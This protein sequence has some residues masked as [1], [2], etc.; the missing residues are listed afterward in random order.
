M[1]SFRPLILIYGILFGL[2]LL[3]WPMKGSF[4]TNHDVWAN[5]AMFETLKADLLHCWEGL[6]Y[7]SFGYP[8][9]NPRI[10]YGLDY[11]SGIF[12]LIFN[13]LLDNPIWS[14]S[15]YLWVLLSL[16]AHSWFRLMRSFGLAVVPAFVSG[17][18]VMANP[19]VIGNLDNP[20]FLAF[21]PSWYSLAIY[22][23][24]RSF[25]SA[26][27]LN[28]SAWLMLLQLLLNPYGLVLM[29]P[30]CF[31]ELNGR[32]WL[33]LKSQHIF[34]WL[35]TFIPVCL[36]LA[37]FAGLYLSDE[38]GDLFN[39]A[40]ELAN[41]A[42]LLR[43]KDFCTG[44]DGALFPYPGFQARTYSILDTCKIGFP[45][46]GLM[47]LGFLGL[48]F[49]ARKAER[50]R[51]LF[52]LFAGIL[53]STALID[54][55]IRNTGSQTKDFFLFSFFRIPFRFYFLVIMALAWCAGLFLSRWPGKACLLILLPLQVGAL[56]FHY[57]DYRSSQELQHLN[58]IVSEVQNL[59]RGPT[60]YFPSAL[61]GEE[62]DKREYKYMY[63]NAL[64]RGIT[65]NGNFAFFDH[66]RLQTDTLFRQGP[67]SFIRAIQPE[68]V[69]LIDSFAKCSEE[70]DS[71]EMPANYQCRE[72]RFGLIIY[73]CPQQAF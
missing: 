62:E 7:L 39:P 6:P 38:H 16:N 72:T 19:F 3:P 67:V 65:F 69:V 9:A 27:K 31:L 68:N 60:A 33:M 13:Q 11:F 42:N 8:A 34:F 23:D 51:I 30:I 49:P 59:K 45:G 20:N 12:Y 70:L 50:F 56:P 48:L 46:W 36:I 52:I 63:I 25:P 44:I 53:L 32:F 5:L 28:L 21:F 43:I 15:L 66:A 17:F 2:Y 4:P 22:R 58:Q 14:Y 41:E 18:L 1:P 73:R 10:N 54:I 24:S 57:P 26:H 71:T 35:F 64:C 47:L 29:V 37:G 61:F 55:L 40:M